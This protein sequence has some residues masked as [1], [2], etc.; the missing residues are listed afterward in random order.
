ALRNEELSTLKNE[1]LELEDFINDKFNS[2]FKNNCDYTVPL[3]DCYVI[4]LNGKKYITTKG[5]CVE[6]TGKI[7]YGHD[8]YLETY[9]Y[10]DV[11][12]TY[13]EKN[14]KRYPRE[15]YRYSI[16][17]GLDSFTK[18]KFIGTKPESE[19]HILQ[20]CPELKMYEGGEVPNTHL[21]KLYYEINNLGAIA[22]GEKQNM[23]K[24]KK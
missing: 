9:I 5:S 10:Y 7:F 19:V 4:S 16:V 3:I 2:E 21:K 18:F 13:H 17:H 23:S 22:S 6:D 14:G 24:V 20:L 8:V 12:S 1:I 11:F 15:L